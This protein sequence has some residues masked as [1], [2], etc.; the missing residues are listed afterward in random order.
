MTEDDNKLNR[1]STRL[2][3]AIPVTISGTDAEGN[4]FRENV[5]TLIVNKHGGKVATAHSLA[6][7]TEILIEN[8]VLGITAKSHVAWLDPEPHD[9]GMYHV[10]LQLQVPRDIWGITFPPDDWTSAPQEGV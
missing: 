4:K 2:S 5:R 1:R 6:M 3:I 8:R 9:G 7:N 10:G